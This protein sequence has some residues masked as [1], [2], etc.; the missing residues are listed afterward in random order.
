M[1]MIGTGALLATMPT[2][3]LAAIDDR[4]TAIKP[5]LELYPLGEEL[6]KDFDGTIEKVARMGFREV[7]VPSFYGK[8]S[9]QVRTALDNAGLGC[10]SAGA[11]PNPLAPGMPSLETHGDLI[12]DAFAKFG[13]RYCV[14]LLPPLRPG[15]KIVDGTFD[16]LSIDDWHFAAGFLNDLGAK[17]AKHGLRFAYH[18]HFWEFL[19]QG[20]ANGFEILMRETDPKLVDFEMDC[21]FV[22]A[23]GGDP[24]K[25]LRD[26]R[27]RIKLLHI[28]DIQA[29]K[30]PGKDLQTVAVGQ[31]IIDWKPVF[32]EM[33]KSDIDQYFIELEP[34][35][36]KPVYTALEESL[37][38]VSG[39]TR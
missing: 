35:F 4:L 3:S 15:T 33:R 16:K 38:F 1:A 30:V 6:V 34:P 26:H 39:L 13:A 12:F 32:A 36:V 28:K 9:A 31:G 22:A 14:N 20:D 27:A 2:G 10:I 7:E 29:R 24:A 18:N 21:A 25:E 23:M 5:G 8:P 37:H 11:L 17:A 19:P